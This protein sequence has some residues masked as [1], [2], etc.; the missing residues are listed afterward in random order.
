M[1]DT[2]RDLEEREDALLQER[3][4]HELKFHRELFT[5]RDRLHGL[6]CRCPHLRPELREEHAALDVRCAQHE[7]ERVDIER[8]HDIVRQ[9]RQH[10]QRRA[11][12]DALIAPRPDDVHAAVAHASGDVHTDTR[13]RHARLRDI[14]ARTMPDELAFQLWQFCD[15]CC[16]TIEDELHVHYKQIQALD[17]AIG[18]IET[19]QLFAHL[20]VYT[21]HVASNVE[22]IDPCTR[23]E[24][25]GAAVRVLIHDHNSQIEACKYAE[26][27]IY[28]E[29]Y[30]IHR[31]FPY[32]AAF[33]T[34]R[35]GRDQY[36]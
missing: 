12:L 34:H 16:Q 8:R 36:S 3:Q 6:E 13:L 32:R 7:R 26:R 31:L 5:E 1:H 28:H 19:R 24:R 10:R 14:V 23:L 27:E 25:A 29:T 18:D 20:S 35:P 11:E 21:P 2:D 22:H 4:A 17:T 9:Q 33:P 15:E 30:H